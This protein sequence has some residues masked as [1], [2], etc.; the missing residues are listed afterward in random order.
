[1]AEAAAGRG[2]LPNSGGRM[3]GAHPRRQI[4]Q[5]DPGRPPRPGRCGA[6]PA[7]WPRPSPTWPP[8]ETL[9]NPFVCC[10][11]KAKLTMRFAPNTSCRSVSFSC[12]VR[13]FA[14]ALPIRR[15]CVVSPSTASH[16]AG[17]DVLYVLVCR[18]RCSIHCSPPQIPLP[19]V[20][21]PHTFPNTCRKNRGTVDIR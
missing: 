15:R 9:W 14:C 3:L 18:P 6:K 1:M 12:R 2:M 5:P 8:R 16:N 11:D 20:A 17:F 4:R 13:I 10:L 21:T 7:F 19:L